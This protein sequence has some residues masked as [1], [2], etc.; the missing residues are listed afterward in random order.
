MFSNLR[1]EGGRTNHLFMPD[2]ALRLAGWQED[3]VRLEAARPTAL[4]K[5]AEE[6]T[7]LVWFDLQRIVR[8]IAAA[9][10][11]QVTLAY[12]RNGEPRIVQRAEEDPELMAEPPWL[13][14]KWLRFRPV[15]ADRGCH[16]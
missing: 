11:T 3:L 6:G 2:R 16:W 8:E 13:A 1:T 10:G 4:K 5:A 7:R 12:V 15:W 14:R 9:G